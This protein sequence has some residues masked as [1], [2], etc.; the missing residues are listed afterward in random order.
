MPW[1]YDYSKWYHQYPQ[2]PLQALAAASLL[3]EYTL[4]DFGTWLSS[5]DSVQSSLNI[6]KKGTDDANDPLLNP[7]HALLGS[8]A[9]NPDTA[10]LFMDWLALSDGGQKVVSTFSKNGTILY[11]PAP[12]AW[13]FFLVP[14]TLNVFM[15]LLRLLP[16]GCTLVIYHYHT[17]KIWLVFVFLCNLVLGQLTSFDVIMTLKFSCYSVCRCSSNIVWLLHIIRVHTY[18]TFGFPMMRDQRLD[19]PQPHRVEGTV[20]DQGHGL[21]RRWRVDNFTQPNEDHTMCDSN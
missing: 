20:A 9:P 19:L 4:T 12:S 6:Y 7:A 2:F 21:F 13:V 18:N 3:S 17:S 15:N 5:P 11:S 10:S 14:L 16:S 1:A 8:M